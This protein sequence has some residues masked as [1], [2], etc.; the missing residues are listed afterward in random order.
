MDDLECFHAFF[1]KDKN[2]KDEEEDMHKCKSCD[3][4]DIVFTYG[5]FCCRNCGLLYGSQI[6]HNAEWRYYG[7][8]DSKSSDPTRCG[9][10]TSSLL[11]QSSLG[12]VVSLQFNGKHSH[13]FY[14]LRKYHQWN[15]M[16]Y[17]E[18][19]LYNVFVQMQSK[20]KK[21]GIS[22]CIIY[23]AKKMYKKISETKITRGSNRKGLI[24]SC[25]Y[26]S[27]KRKGVPRSAKEISTIFDIKPYEMTRGVKH[28]LEIMNLGENKKSFTI[29]AS[30]AVD[31]IE[32]FCSN[33]ELDDKIKEL[34]MHISKKA[35]E[36]S[37]VDENT[38]PSIAAGS[39]YLVCS[40]FSIGITKKQVAKA[41]N[42]SEVTISK[43]Y[44]KLHKYKHMFGL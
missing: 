5:K 18:R 10:A 2:I 21:A 6:E 8:D 19:S 16:P 28:F 43:C 7:V 33:L 44:K 29:K 34:C 4:D 30:T 23:E 1:K 20:A 15:A 40:H 14:K 13:D 11:P 38:P 35:T 32:R 27:C 24:A 36:I 9:M 39:I 26:V 25:I 31:F 17:K 3:S 42:T 22:D 37:I 12:S 41:C